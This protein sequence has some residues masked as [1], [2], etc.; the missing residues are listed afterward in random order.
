MRRIAGVLRDSDGDLGAAAARLVTLE[1]AWQPQ[2]KLRTPLDYVVATLRALEAPQPQPDPPSLVAASPALGQ[3]FW[4]APQPNGWPDRAADWAG[5]EALL[6]RIDWAYAVAGRF[7]GA[8]PGRGG[9]GEPRSAAAAR[10]AQGHASV[11]AR[12]ATR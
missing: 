9:R 1:A 7:G 5:P 8:R 10:H 12:G 3:P 2:T 11:R 4:T 6:R